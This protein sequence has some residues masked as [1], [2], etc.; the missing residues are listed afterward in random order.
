MPFKKFSILFPGFYILLLLAFVSGFLF[1]NT[2]KKTMLDSGDNWGY[3]SYLP[4]TFIYKDL[5]TLDSTYVVRGRIGEAPINPD[6]MKNRVGEAPD[7]GNGNRVI[8]YTMGVAIM[9][10][11]FFLIAHISQLITGKPANGFSLPYII[12][13]YISTL[14]YVFI[15]F[16]LLK[17][18]LI[19]WFDEK[20]VFW[21]LTA[22][23]FATNLFYF[24]VFNSGMSHSYLFFLYCLLINGTVSFHDNPDYKNGLKLAVALGMISLTRPSEIIAVLIPLLYGVNSITGLREKLDLVRK[25]WKLIIGMCVV[26]LL[27]SLPQ[28]IYWKLLTGHWIYDSYPGEHFDFSN[29]HILEAFFSWGNGWLTYTPVMLLIF[30]GFFLLKGGQKVWRFP[31]VF[32]FIIHIYIIYSWWCWYYSNGYGSRPMVELYPLLAIPLAAAIGRLMSFKIG[33]IFSYVLISFLAFINIFQTVQIEHG[34]YYSDVA[35]WKFYKQRFLKW[36]YTYDDLLALDNAESQPDLNKIALRKRL[37]NEGFEIDTAVHRDSIIVKKGKYAALAEP[38]VEYNNLVNLTLAD[39]DILSKDYIKITMSAWIN[40]NPG[41][42]DNGKLVAE[43]RRGGN[44][45]RGNIL[46]IE[47]KLRTPED[48]FSI[49]GGE[50]KKWK[51]FSFFMQV[52]GDL[53][54]TDNLFIYSW[55]PSNTTYRI[56]DISIELWRSIK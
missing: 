23:Y 55:N 50:T 53:K 37:F 11:P 24:T 17:K 26:I 7:V 47:N 25:N 13:V 2:W 56:D 3:Y 39:P 48:N 49:W 46:R 54:K 32:V 35:T 12:A 9:Q 34:Y 21:T 16:V 8:K 43:I 14:F 38:G 22:L 27:I 4:A 10:C 29:P 15:G 51:S 45:I 40:N 52:P 36:H 44:K 18:T 41:I 33:E 19:K 31:I 1:F 6:G 42:F 5:P 28:L 20:T 30:P